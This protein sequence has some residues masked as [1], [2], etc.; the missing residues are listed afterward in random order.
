ML[1][2]GWRPGWDG[3]YW[4]GRISS[5][6]AGDGLGSRRSDTPRIGPWITPAVGYFV[7]QQK[8]LEEL[9]KARSILAAQQGER[10]DQ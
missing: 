5:I 1:E 9:A 8:Y 4:I 3:L 7:G 6:R 10:P 2:M